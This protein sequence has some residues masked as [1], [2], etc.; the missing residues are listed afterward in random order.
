MKSPQNTPKLLILLFI[1]PI[2]AEV[3]SDTESVPN[4][5]WHLHG[6]QDFYPCIFIRG[7]RGQGIIECPSKVTAR[8]GDTVPIIN[9]EGKHV[10]ELRLF[11]KESKLTTLT[12]GTFE[13]L[14]DQL[15]HL[16][17]AGAD[18]RIIHRKAFSGLV[19]L[20]HLEIRNGIFGDVVGGLSSRLFTADGELKHLKRLETLTLENVDL[21]DGLAAYAFYDLSKNLVQ[22]ELINN[23]LE[24]INPY[25]FEKSDCS[26]S[27]RR[28]ALEKQPHSPSWL[29]EAYRWARDLGNL[30]AISL[31]GNNLTGKTLNFGS[32]VNQALKSLQLVGCSFTGIPQDL[33]ASFESLQELDL[34]DNTFTMISSEEAD[35]VL[36]GAQQLLHLTKL[37]LRRNRGLV[38]QQPRWF[39]TSSIRELDYGGS[40]LRRLTANQLPEGLQTL[41]LD[42]TYLADIAQDWS[43]GMHNLSHLYL[44]G[45][46]LRPIRVGGLLGNL[47]EALRPLRSSLITLGLSR[48]QLIAESLEPN[49]APAPVDGGLLLGLQDLVNLNSLDLSHNYLTYIP[50]G[51]FQKL[52]LLTHLNLSSNNLQTVETLTWSNH[53]KRSVK[54]YR[55]GPMLELLDLSNNSLTRLS[56]KAPSLG[57]EISLTEMLN[58]TDSRLLLVGNPLICDCRLL[59]LVFSHTKYDN[60]VC[61]GSNKLAQVSFSEIKTPEQQLS[62]CDTIVTNAKDPV[63]PFRPVHVFGNDELAKRIYFVVKPGALQEAW[64]N[65]ARTSAQDEAQKLHQHVAV[66][67]DG[68]TSLDLINALP[69]DCI[70]FAVTFW[71][72]AQ[73]DEVVVD[74]PSDWQLVERRLH[75]K[76]YIFAVEPILA[77][78]AYT[79]CFRNVAKPTK[80]VGSTLCQIFQPSE[81]RLS[82]KEGT[83][84]PGDW[85][86]EL[87]NSNNR[88]RLPFWM[89]IVLI[90]TAI[91]L[92]LVLVCL[93]IKY[94]LWRKFNAKKQ[95]EAAYFR[96]PYN[97]TPQATKEDAYEGLEDYSL[98]ISLPNLTKETTELPRRTKNKYTNGKIGISL[99]KPGQSSASL[100]DLRADQNFRLFRTPRMRHFGATG[101]HDSHQ[102]RRGYVP[103]EAHSLLCGTTP[104]T[105]NNI[106]TS[107]RLPPKPVPSPLPKL[108]TFGYVEMNA[109]VTANTK[110]STKTTSSMLVEDYLEVKPMKRLR[111]WE[112]EERGIMADSYLLMGVKPPPAPTIPT[113]QKSRSRRCT[114]APYEE[115]Q[116]EEK[117]GG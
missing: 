31:G 54:S 16:V 74:G 43:I 81:L 36:A 17:I 61:S 51:A 22:L 71:P 52:T 5:L 116:E 40:L 46:S 90:V 66:N 102:Q 7:G 113:P 12:A 62:F 47:A 28:L 30:E 45:S 9:P 73:F 83:T 59:W 23:N 41:H 48:C 1:A 101:T 67:S 106:V 14:G 20:R 65:V 105:S 64:E 70:V 117:R 68:V 85:E 91:A 44:N 29:A 114:T 38:H 92:L 75:D 21:S 15:E 32:G 104:R 50:L 77:A 87:T 34:A 103:S 56:Q 24:T 55:G 10:Q 95:E 57:F 82:V 93:A 37:S 108:D 109:T 53:T 72:L 79:V 11:A 13:E 63:Y 115:S 111:R 33:L 84:D 112:D 98:D 96:A 110:M 42:S 60:F 86:D 19:K 2:F 49:T 89:I 80:E 3:A 6:S 94:Y 39:R 69:A 18:L 78:R 25:A 97:R 58:Q 88:S 99:V 35:T 107:P 26:R 27:L 4:N 76:L 100:G 8:F